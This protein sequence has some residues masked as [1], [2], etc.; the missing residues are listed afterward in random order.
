MQ[1]M[2]E[3]GKTR[4]KWVVASRCYFPAD[5]PEAVGRPFSPEI[6]EVNF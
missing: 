6:N 5:L 3:D 4:S 1:S 2:W